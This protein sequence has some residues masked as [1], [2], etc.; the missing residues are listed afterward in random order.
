MTYGIFLAEATSSEKAAIL[1]NGHS[2]RVVAP[3]RL[4]GRRMVHKSG[5]YWVGSK[6]GGAQVPVC[7]SA[8]CFLVPGQGSGLEHRSHLTQPE[9]LLVTGMGS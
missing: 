7:L 3:E 1:N 5:Q 9:T 2:L 8:E 6:A 4:D